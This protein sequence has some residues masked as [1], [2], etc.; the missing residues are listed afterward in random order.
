MKKVL[1]SALL[2]ASL[3]AMPLTASA[4]EAGTWDYVGH[5][6]FKSQ[7]VVVYS[8]GGDFRA[9]L[10]AGYNWSGYLTL[11][12]Y[13]AENADEKVSNQYITPSSCA[14]WRGIGG[15]VDGAQAEFYVTKSDGATI[16]VKFYD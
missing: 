14:V 5:S 11:W 16:D 3:M 9:C 8:N 7:S 2:G 13:D 6:V 10:A 15:F 1:L 12:E 4:E